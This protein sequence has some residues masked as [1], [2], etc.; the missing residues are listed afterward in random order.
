MANA[1]GCGGSPRIDI[2]DDATVRDWVASHPPRATAPNSSK[3]F[4][5][6]R[7]RRADRGI[8]PIARGRPTSTRF[9]IFFFRHS[10]GRQSPAV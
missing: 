1:A 6:M 2:D 10:I 3:I 4:E 8:T 5:L 9:M 7:A